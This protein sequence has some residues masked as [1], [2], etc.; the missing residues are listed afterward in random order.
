M[1]SASAAAEAAMTTLAT[2]LATSNDDEA[3]TAVDDLNCPTYSD[4][5][6]DAAETF[7]FWVEGVSQERMIA[8]DFG[9]LENMELEKWTNANVGMKATF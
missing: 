7:S 3:A 1:T 2:F 9:E 8:C 6:E 4:E 5:A